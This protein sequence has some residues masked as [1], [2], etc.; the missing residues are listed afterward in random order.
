MPCGRLGAALLQCA[1]SRSSHDR[2]GGWQAEQRA[3]LRELQAVPKQVVQDLHNAAEVGD[4]QRR[5]GVDAALYGNLRVG[6]GVG[7]KVCSALT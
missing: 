6:V 4:N 5:P 2:H 1:H 7:R 3:H